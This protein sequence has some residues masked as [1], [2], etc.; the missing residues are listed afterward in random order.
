M[1]NLTE[2]WNG[3][4]ANADI[5]VRAPKSSVFKA[6]QVASI[7]AQLDAG[8]PFFVM[9]GGDVTALVTSKKE[10]TDVQPCLTQ[11]HHFVPF[12]H[13][14][15]TVLLKQDLYKCLEQACEL[16]NALGKDCDWMDVFSLVR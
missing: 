7:L 16:K 11:L 5:L 8:W 10:L 9:L 2:D 13:R 12:S 4:F 14:L 6:D 1:V 15:P 3:T